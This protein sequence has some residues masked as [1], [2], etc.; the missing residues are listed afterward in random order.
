MYL[1]EAYKQLSDDRFYH[2]IDHDATYVQHKEVA[3]AIGQAIS[4]CELPPQAKH[5]TVEHP[6]TSKF[7]MLPK[8]HKAGNP[9][10]PIVSACNC[11]TSNISA[12]LDSVRDG[13]SCETTIKLRERHKSR[14]SN[15]GIVYFFRPK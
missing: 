8:I 4:T 9:G 5:L 3:N 12:Y 11:P 1:E 2:Q 14:T 7:Y 13:S 6:R 10:R 15:P